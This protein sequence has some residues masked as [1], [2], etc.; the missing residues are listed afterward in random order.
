MIS[1]QCFV[2]LSS[3]DLE[4]ATLTA[5]AWGWRPCATGWK[6]PDGLVVRFVPHEEIL[7]QWRAGVLFLDCLPSPR[8]E[9]IV[10]VAKSRDYRIRE[11][12]PAHGESV[13]V[14]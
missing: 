4:S 13:R 11:P 8:R 9:A 5:E 10:E 12:R 3:R 7:R 6:T 14:L 1:K 2:G